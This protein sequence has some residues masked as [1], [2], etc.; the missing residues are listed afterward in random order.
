MET[1]TDL[2][3]VATIQP[4]QAETYWVEIAGNEMI[5]IPHPVQVSGQLSK[6]AILELAFD[7][8]L[9]GDTDMGF[10]T[11]PPGTRLL[12][13]EIRSRGIYVN[14]SKEFASGGGSASMI[15]R[16]GQVIFTASSIDPEEPVFLAVEGKLIDQ[17]N[18]LGGEGLLLNQPTLR[19]EFVSQY[20]MY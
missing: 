7:E 2:G 15:E 14:L 17:E 18:P 13:L 11:I 9:A 19:R 1:P 8:L 20:P 4:M 5:L 3:P 16:V 12:D 10:S 6:E